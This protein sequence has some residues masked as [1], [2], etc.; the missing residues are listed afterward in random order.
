M[1]RVLVVD[2]HPSVRAGLVAML[3]SEAGLVPVGAVGNAEEALGYLARDATDVLLV[4]Y[5]LPDSDGLELCWD[6][7]C[8][9]DPP[10]VLIYSAFAR[11]RLAIAATLAG[12]DA[13]LDK[14]ADPDRLFELVRLVAGGGRVVTRVAPE[15]I[16]RCVAELDPDDIPLFGMAFNRL[17]VAEIAA[18][19]GYD[20]ETAQTRLRAIIGRLHSTSVASA[21]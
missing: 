19:S 1:I 14:G 12:A 2:D 13:M 15:L 5:H 11:P 6:A 9:D 18:V 16:R 4:D 7:K 3:R 10:A 17:P 8:R 20:I 21:A